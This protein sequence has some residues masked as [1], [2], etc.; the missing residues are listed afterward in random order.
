MTGPC[1][2]R[3]MSAICRLRLLVVVDQSLNDFGEDRRLD[4]AHDRLYA[5]GGLEPSE[6]GKASDLTSRS[7]RAPSLEAHAIE[8]LRHIAPLDRADR[9][10]V[11][12]R[13]R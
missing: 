12:V 6:K 5:N 9:P 10:V 4:E 13:W 1:S 2:G 11:P 8:R 7:M 3:N